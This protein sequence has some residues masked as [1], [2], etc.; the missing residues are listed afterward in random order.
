MNE[1]AWSI[2]GKI[3][4][5]ENRRT[6]R[7]TCSSAT[8]SATNPTQ[9]GLRQRGPSYCEADWA[10]AR[11]RTVFLVRVY[12]CTLCRNTLFRLQYLK[13]W[14]LLTVVS[15]FTNSLNYIYTVSTMNIT[16]IHFILQYIAASLLQYCISYYLLAVLLPCYGVFYERIYV[17]RRGLLPN[18]ANLL[19]LC[20]LCC[21]RWM[22][23]R[24]GCLI[25]CARSGVVKS[26]VEW[27]FDG[28]TLAVRRSGC[29]FANMQIQRQ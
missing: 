25:N 13:Y 11:H 5:G 12:K 10:V 21:W 16:H 20:L 3:L 14:K 28:L 27:Q 24:S 9:S 1:W 6:V 23:L 4:T 8:L 17:L 15:A 2:G 22:C 26:V 7:K 19:I 18:V 29:Y